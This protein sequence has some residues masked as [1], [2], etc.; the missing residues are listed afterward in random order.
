MVKFVNDY[1]SRDSVEKDAETLYVFGDNMNGVG[2][3]G[4]ACIRGLKNAVGI[5]TK[6]NIIPD[7]NDVVHNEFFIDGIH[8]EKFYEALEKAL[9]YI[10]DWPG[11]VVI[12]AEIGRGLA[13]FHETAPKLY[14][15]MLYKLL[16]LTGEVNFFEDTL[17]DHGLIHHRGYF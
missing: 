7:K 1:W 14:A 10:Y 9:D 3:A 13:M 17:D 11:D 4:Q 2:G 12:H 5:P 8:D 6:N 16:V 15:H